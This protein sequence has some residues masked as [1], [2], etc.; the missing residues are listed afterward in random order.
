MNQIFQQLENAIGENGQADCLQVL[1]DHFR[2]QKNYAELFEVLKMQ[3]RNRMGLPVVQPQSWMES[4][5]RKSES[6]LPPDKQRELED[7]LLDACREVGTL[8]IQEGQIAEGWVYLEPLGDDPQT[9]ELFESVNVNEENLDVLIDVALGQRAN[10]RRGFELLI[11][12]RGTC[13][14]ITTFESFGVH[15]PYADQQQLAT[16]L[17]DHVYD[18]LQTNVIKHLKENDKP[19]SETASLRELIKDHEWLFEN[20]GHHLDVTHLAS[21]VRLTRILED[22]S[23]LNKALEISQYGDQLSDNLK[24]PGQAPFEDTFRDHA[25]FFDGLVQNDAETAIDH[26]RQKSELETRAEGMLQFPATEQYVML[27]HRLGKTSNAIDVAIEHLAGTDSMASAW[28]LMELT[29]SVEDLQKIQNHCR[30]K[31]DVLTFGLCLLQQHGA[32]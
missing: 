3:A 21:V 15:L 4:K 27:L 10:P 14:A 20:S 8:M 5:E 16:V 7:Q 31:S 2:T 30:E 32:S 13:N 9:R 18:E 28:R 29:G 19:A 22:K 26:F 23:S 1:S 11:Q 6:K 25:I 24:L 12:Q 17:L